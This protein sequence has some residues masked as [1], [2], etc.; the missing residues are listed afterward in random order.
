MLDTTKVIEAKLEGFLLSDLILM[1]KELDSEIA[2]ARQNKFLNN[3][4]SAIQAMNSVRRAI[5]NKIDEQDPSF[6]TNYVA[7]R[8][9]A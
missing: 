5:L 4:Y 7:E 8:V 6:H 9:E 2:E 3:D 1:L